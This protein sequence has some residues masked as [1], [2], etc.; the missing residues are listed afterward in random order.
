MCIVTSKKV[1]LPV[2][3]RKHRIHSKSIVLTKTTAAQNEV[4]LS[5]H[6]VRGQYFLAFVF[7]ATIC[8]VYFA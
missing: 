5:Y 2:L 1:E 8:N 7:A 3:I 6:K 4:A